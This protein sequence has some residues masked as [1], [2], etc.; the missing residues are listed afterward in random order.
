MPNRALV[1]P[2][3]EE[4]GWHSGAFPG[5]GVLEDNPAVVLVTPNQRLGPV[6]TAVAPGH[7]VCKA[8]PGAQG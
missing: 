7:G 8:D 5:G 4:A 1:T 2:L 6:K 3:L